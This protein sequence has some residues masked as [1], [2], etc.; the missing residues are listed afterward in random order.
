MISLLAAA[1]LSPVAI[2]EKLDNGAWIVAVPIKGAASF[3]A[4]TFIRAGSVFETPE[5]SGASHLLEHLLFA[6]GKADMIAESAGFILNATTYREFMSLQATGPVASWRKGIEAVNQ[7]LQGPD[8]SK[9]ANESKVVLQEEKLASL[10]PDELIHRSLWK[11][12]VPSNAWELL[13]VGD[14]LS[15]P[16]L[17]GPSLSALFSHHFS[18]RNVVAVVSGDFDP[19]EAV[20]ALRAAYRGLAPG[21]T[22]SAPPLPGFNVA[23]TSVSAGEERVGIS[24][25]ILGYGEVPS[26]LAYEIIFDAMLS[27]GRLEPLGLAARSFAG[28]SSRGS[29]ACFSFR[30]TDGAPDLEGRVSRL[31]YS[32]KSGLPPAEILASRAKLAARYSGETPNDAALIA[33]LG[34]LFLGRDASLAGDLEKVK[35]ADIQK[36]AA[37][38]DPEKVSWSTGR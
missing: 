6:D 15:L 38:L 24:L 37:A 7:L 36:A 29:I 19:K 16:K 12:A 30:S 3:T 2:S 28:P 31:L 5:T 20:A 4:Q 33:G 8:L 26:F 14:P 32:M 10:D 27:P 23:R 25:P 21:S 11:A 34:F 22:Q 18:G 13:P 9:I 17:T 1:V 35:D